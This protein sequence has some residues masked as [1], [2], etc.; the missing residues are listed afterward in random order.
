MGGGGGVGGPGA[1]AGKKLSCGFGDCKMLQILK[2][3]PGQ[4]VITATGL[5]AGQ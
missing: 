2:C 1:S 3:S 5:L 4:S